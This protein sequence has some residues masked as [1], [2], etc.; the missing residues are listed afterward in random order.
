MGGTTATVRWDLYREIHKAMRHALFGVTRLAG[1]ADPGD[2]ASTRRLL[3]EWREVRFVL[4]GHH[5]HEDE[6]C[7]PLVRRHAP[8]LRDELEAGHDAAAAGLARIDA[9]THRIERAGAPE[10]QE[11]LPALHLD[12][13][14]FTASYLHHLEF[15]ESR[16]MPALDRV[17]PDEDLER[18]TNQI[19]GNVPPADMCRYLHYMVP[20]M[21]F[22]ER[23]D[24]LGGM[25]AG[26]PPEIFE[27][28]RDA[29]ERALSEPEFQ[30]VALA[31]GF[32]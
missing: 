24:M 10:R 7:D 19:R 27:L 21:T 2:E 17:L 13:A 23:L 30:A 29:A 26:A 6:H 16:A 25:H 20:A 9:S 28:F 3:D 1:V 15:E 12:L 11:L 22:S 14:G 5:E 4:V 31:V 8:E 32:A 18:V